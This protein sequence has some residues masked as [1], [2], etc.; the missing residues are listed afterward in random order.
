MSRAGISQV[1]ADLQKLGKLGPMRRRGRYNHSF[2]CPFHSKGK[3]QST[4]SFGVHVETGEWNCFNPTCARKGPSIQALYAALTG[5]P[6]DEVEAMFPA[7]AGA[8]DDIRAK[9]KAE[10]DKDLPA[11]MA[12]F[13]RT[14]PIQSDAAAATYMASRRIPQKVWEA[15]GLSFA[16]A[17]RLAAGFT[18]SATFGGRRI[19]FPI[20]LPGAMGFMGRAIGPDRTA[21]WRPISNVGKLFYDPLG[22]LKRPIPPQNVVLVEGEFD[23]AACIR[24]SLDV[25]GCF[26]AGVG[27]EIAPV[28]QRFDRVMTMFDGD[29]AGWEATVA[30]QAAHG[31]ML[32]GRILTYRLQQNA[33]PAGLPIG[34]GQAVRAKFNEKVSFADSLR[35]RLHV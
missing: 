9:L 4:P 14:V 21:K 24:E 11:P 18:G 32:R 2:D 22:I 35:S 23:V 29:K 19:I 31:K 16:P 6:Q 28:L 8:T 5:K 12:P 7:D 3:R 10:P 33:D 30:F 20:E 15:M 1:L 34:F 17:P 13:P 26:R 27:P 25:L